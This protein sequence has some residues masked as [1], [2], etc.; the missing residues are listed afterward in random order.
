MNEERSAEERIGAWL[1]GEAPDQL[2]DRVLQATFDQMRTDRQRHRLGW[3][4]RW[5]N[6]PMSS[7]ARILA[8]AAAV[9]VAV[10][11]FGVVG[12]GL[13]SGIG[14]PHPTPSATPAPSG[15]G[16]VF[17]VTFESPTSWEVVEDATDAFFLAAPSGTSTGQGIY[18]LRGAAI[19][20]LDTGCTARPDPARGDAVLDFVDYVAAHPNYE[21]SQTHDVTIGGLSGVT[22]DL[23]LVGSLEAPCQ[24]VNGSMFLAQGVGEGW[25]SW[26]LSSGEYQRVAFLDDGA[27]G[28]IVVI[29][30]ARGQTK[31]DLMT[32]DAAPIIDSLR[33]LS[34]PP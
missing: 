22:L 16:S 34:P 10:V 2:P 28:T 20:A 9:L 33:F 30:N 18:I 11:G 26:G 4:L 8:A 31:F 23:T 5:R 19:P 1:R 3:D 32:A 13:E 27:D 21:R 25:S 6:R 15:P 24:Y 12:R 29:V 7:S 14:G 17:G